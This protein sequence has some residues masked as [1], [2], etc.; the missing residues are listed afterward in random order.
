MSRIKKDKDTATILFAKNDLPKKT[1]DLQADLLALADQEFKQIQLD[2]AKTAEINM[3]LLTL[4]IAAQN[5]FIRR[6]ARMELLNCSE[7]LL[8]FI[9]RMNLIDFLGVRLSA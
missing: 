8:N 6:G 7:Q 4:L 1:A 9:A 3:A 2:F 5:S